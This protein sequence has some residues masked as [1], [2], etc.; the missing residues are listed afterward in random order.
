MTEK[1]TQFD[2]LLNAMH[3]AGMEE[4]PALAGYGDKR[5]AL[6]EHVRALEKGAER[7]SKLARDF[8][9]GSAYMDGNH[10]WV[11]RR[12][13]SLRGPTLAAALDAVPAVGAA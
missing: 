13:F 11:Y 2:Y 7:Y 3:H 9:V 5:R 6:F 1:L 4:N 10:V 8:S 12:N